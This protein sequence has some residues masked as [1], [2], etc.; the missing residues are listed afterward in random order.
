MFA[1]YG[2][3]TRY[4]SRKDSKPPQLFLDRQ[5]GSLAMNQ[6][7]RMV[8][9]PYDGPEL[10]LDGPVVASQGALG[11]WLLIRCYE[12]GPRPA[13]A[14]S[15]LPNLQLVLFSFWFAWVFFR[16]DP[17][18]CLLFWCCLIVSGRSFFTLMARA[19]EPLSLSL[20]TERTGCGSPP[21][22][23]CA[24][25]GSVFCHRRIT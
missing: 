12:V 3:L 25:I 15:P 17:E 6:R 7:R 1:L 8:W 21:Q 16:N 11:H 23:G 10:G 18:R 9:E 20:A 14:G 5:R 22:T 24:V 19:A 13:A 2:L 4:A